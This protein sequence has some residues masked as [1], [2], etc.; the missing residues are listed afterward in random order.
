[1][2]PKPA[3]SSKSNL[4]REKQVNDQHL[5]QPLY[6]LLQVLDFALQRV[7]LLPSGSDLRLHVHSDLEA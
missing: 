7:D 5:V 4:I 3:K 2:K 1:M 6:G